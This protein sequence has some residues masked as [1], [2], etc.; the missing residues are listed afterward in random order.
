MNPI[1]WRARPLRSAGSSPS[2]R[3]VPSVGSSSP[4]ISRTAVV[5]PAPLGPITPTI[6]PGSM[7]RSTSDRA[8]VSPNRRVTPS[9]RTIAEGPLGA[10]I[11]RSGRRGARWSGPEHHLQTAGLDGREQVSTETFDEDDD[12]EP[13]RVVEHDGGRHDHPVGVAFGTKPARDPTA[14]LPVEDPARVVG[15]GHPAPQVP[16]AQVRDGVERH[17][18]GPDGDLV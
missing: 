3:T 16:A 12:G 10:S 4:V 8:T 1:D 15:D 5:F 11:V 18:R 9:K 17:P 2:T 13:A 6:R 7:S 14:P